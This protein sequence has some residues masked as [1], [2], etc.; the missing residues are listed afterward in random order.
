MDNNNQVLGD[1]DVLFISKK[2]KRIAICETKNFELSRNMYELHF[3]YMDM[4]EP[5]NEKSFY[6]K[7]MKR[8]NWCKENIDNIK[9]QYNLPDIK[10]KIDYCFIVNEPLVS[11]KAMKAN[12]RAYTIEEIDKF[13]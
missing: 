6:N 1:I 10:W 12:V 3:E 5:N 4:F 7:H 9:I 2:K 13:I 8:V 11:N